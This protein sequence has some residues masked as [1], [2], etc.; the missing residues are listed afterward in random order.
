[1]S[2]P[3]VIDPDASNGGEMRR[4]SVFVLRYADVKNCIKL[5]FKGQ[6]EK[7]GSVLLLNDAWWKWWPSRGLLTTDP[8]SSLYTWLIGSSRG[9]AA[10]GRLRWPRIRSTLFLSILL[11]LFS[12]S[13]VAGAHGKHK[14]CVCFRSNMRIVQMSARMISI[15]PARG[16]KGMNATC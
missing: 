12:S 7:G 15:A 1:M 5:F 16:P 6:R 14:I 3:G 10:D 4:R 13:A 11:P 9:A 2:A 8:C